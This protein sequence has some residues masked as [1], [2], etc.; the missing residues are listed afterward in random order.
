MLDG[1]LLPDRLP[2]PQPA[3]RSELDQILQW[4]DG[5]PVVPRYA[6]LPRVS[7]PTLINLLP[8]HRPLIEMRIDVD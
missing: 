7:E 6:P 1:R 3:A 8:E 4:R 2:L 5:E